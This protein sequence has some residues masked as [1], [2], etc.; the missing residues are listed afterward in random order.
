MKVEMIEII[1][2]LGERHYDVIQQW[3]VTPAQNKEMG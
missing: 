2:I 3:R 1:D